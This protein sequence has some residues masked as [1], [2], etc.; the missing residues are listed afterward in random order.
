MLSCAIS[1]VTTSSVRCAEGGQHHSEN[2]HLVLGRH[3]LD[4]DHFAMLLFGGTPGQAIQ[5]AIRLCAARI[6]HQTIVFERAVVDLAIAFDLQQQ[7]FG[8][9]P[10]IHQHRPQG[11]LFLMDAVAQ[12]LGHMVE[13]TL[14]ITGRIVD[15]IGDDPKLIGIVAEMLGVLGVVHKRV[16][17]LAHEQI[18][19]VGETRNAFCV[20]F[21]ATT[22]NR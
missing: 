9:I 5:A 8:R 18:L 21:D 16:V 3:T 11:Q 14:A 10:G 7:I 22:L 2:F 12:H 19:T 6:V 20:S 17:D 4:F 15:P 13:F 1:L